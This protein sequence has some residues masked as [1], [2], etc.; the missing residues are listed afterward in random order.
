VAIWLIATNWVAFLDVTGDAQD[1]AQIAK[2]ADLV[3]V[4]LDSYLT[5]EARHELSASE[6]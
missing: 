5:D 1:P 3:L 2:G 6:T 4:V